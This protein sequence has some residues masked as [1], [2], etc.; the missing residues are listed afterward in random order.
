MTQTGPRGVAGPGNAAAG[1]P[2][3]DSGPGLARPGARAL[4]GLGS[5]GQGRGP[6]VLRCR[7]VENIGPTLSRPR[8]QPVPVRP[9][10]RAPG[11]ALRPR[12]IRMIRFLLRAC[13]LLVACQRAAAR[14]L[15]PEAQ[16][17]F[18]LRLSGR[19]LRRLAASESARLSLTEAQA[20]LRLGARAVQDPGCCGESTGGSRLGL[21]PRPAGPAG[22]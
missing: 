16:G 20:E 15:T 22:S 5:P 11:A 13:G 17:A 1:S 12:R 21:A 10:R 7:G 8:A 18:H 14:S 2:S 9:R 19:S 3:A 4:S 6:T